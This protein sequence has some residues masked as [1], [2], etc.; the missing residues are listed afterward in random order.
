M[1]Q[2]KQLN[3]L[4]YNQVMLII[5][6][7]GNYPHKLNKGIIKDFLDGGMEKKL[8]LRDLREFKEDFKLNSGDVKSLKE[9]KKDEYDKIS[10]WTPEL[11]LVKPIDE[12]KIPGFSKWVEYN[13]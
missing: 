12:S 10:F 4:T 2:K 11:D 9:E 3:S 7:I 5:R 13:G 8:F 1:R 6:I